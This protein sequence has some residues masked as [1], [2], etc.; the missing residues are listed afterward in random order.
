VIAESARNI[1]GEHVTAPSYEYKEWK[2][3]RGDKI[4]GGLALGPCKVEHVFV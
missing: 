3:R 4:L 1:P 2:I